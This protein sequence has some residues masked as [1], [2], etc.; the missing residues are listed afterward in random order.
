MLA[1]RSSEAAEGPAA[2]VC[3]ALAFQSG[4]GGQADLGLISQ[5]VL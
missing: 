4:D 3:G 2:A 5:L 1:K